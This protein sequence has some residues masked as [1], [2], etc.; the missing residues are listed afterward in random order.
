MTLPL[1][2]LRSA[3]LRPG[4]AVIPVT[5]GIQFAHGLV[6]AI[7]SWFCSRR[8]AMLVMSILAIGTSASVL[9]TADPTWWHLHFS[10]L[11]TFDDISGYLFNTTLIAAG[12]IIVW[13]ARRVHIE[14]RHLTAL[15]GR[16]PS[17]VLIALIASVGLH[18]MAVGFIPVNT[19]E[20][21][22]DRAASGLMLS[23]LGIL[24]TTL[25]LWRH[26]PRSLLAATIAVFGGLSVA[27]AG[28]ATGLL[29]LAALELVGFSLIFAWISIF[30][31]CVRQGVQ[32]VERR[33]RGEAAEAPTRDQAAEAPTP[34]EASFRSVP[35]GANRRRGGHPSAIGPVSLR[36]PSAGSD[37]T[38]GPGRRPESRR[39]RMQRIPSTRPRSHPRANS[40]RPPY[41]AP[42]GGR[43]GDC[44]LLRP[45][46]TASAGR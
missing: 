16:R 26:V 17:L 33:A 22:H 6:L 42:R 13:F 32:A 3:P 7:L 10:K 15:S 27:I 29:N 39:P 43:R 35:T 18:L 19:N 44:A 28:F 46:C 5:G 45:G 23:F 12:L 30:T 1:S 38:G 41:C 31:R 14:L 40:A 24:L 8:L 9:T 37:A 11:G 20:F 36:L 25:R 21:L 34:D 2:S 4:E